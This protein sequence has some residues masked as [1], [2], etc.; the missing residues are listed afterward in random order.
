MRCRSCNDEASLGSG[1]RVGFHDD[2]QRCGA[3]LHTCHNCLFH[4]PSAH[5]ECR[6]SSAERV[7][8][9]ERANRCEYFRPGD[10]EGGD[11]QARKQA[12]DDLDVLFKK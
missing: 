5:N 1:D 12:I 7:S 10:A 8:Q 2:C 6:E 4:D 9:R 3:D 11:G